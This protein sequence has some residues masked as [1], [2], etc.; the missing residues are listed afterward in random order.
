[1][2]KAEARVTRKRRQRGS[3]NSD[4]IVAGAFA[5]AQRISLDQMSMP[6]LAENLDVGVTSIYWYFRK[7][8]DLLNA[9]TDVAADKFARLM[10]EVRTE[11]S[12]QETLTARLRAE[13]DLFREDEILSDL[14]F[15][16]TSTYSRAATHRVMELVEVMVA[17]LITSGFTPD[18][19]VMAFCA[20]DLYTRGS[21][22]TDRILRM[23]NSPTTDTARQRRMTD[24][25]QLPVLDSLV[26]RHT[27][28]GTSD[29]DF[30]FGVA[31]LI[32]G[33]EQLL[34]EQDG[35][36]GKTPRGSGSARRA[37][38]EKPKAAA[39]RESSARKAA[40][41]SEAATGQEA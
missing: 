29:E 7:K 18:N 40:S 41:R 10:P 28:S 30:E 15:I 5:L 32:A 24:W 25:S 8:E 34:R 6:L 3:I 13:R 36:P 27:L 1:V 2:P 31:R 22:I 37:M 12:W 19:A 17:K 9:M 38:A 21:I 14:L 35:Q 33:F 26:D 23:A 16:R 4:D 39:A 11:D 20:A